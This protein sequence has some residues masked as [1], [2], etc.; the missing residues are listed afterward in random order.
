MR[1]RFTDQRQARRL[2]PSVDLR[3]CL[4]SGRR[5]VEYSRVGHNREELVQARPRQRP[6]HTTLSEILNTRRRLPV[7]LAIRAM[8]IDQNVGVGRDH[9]SWLCSRVS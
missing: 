8:C 6:S 3:Q 2:K 4:G 1:L 9:L 7:P 5:R